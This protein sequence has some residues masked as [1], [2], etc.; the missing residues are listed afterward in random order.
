MNDMVFERDEMFEVILSDPEGGAKVG[1][2]NRT[3]V[4]ITNDDGES[5][6]YCEARHNLPGAGRHYI[7]EGLIEGWVV[8]HDV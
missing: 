7:R 6:I 1:G 4:T 3:A 8:L 2:I 5:D